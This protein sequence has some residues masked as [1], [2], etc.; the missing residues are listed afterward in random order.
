MKQYETKTSNDYMT[1]HLVC[2]HFSSS[3]VHVIDCTLGEVIRSILAR[4]D[5]PQM[6]Q[7]LTWCSNI[8]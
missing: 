1:R 7:Q 6:K 5:S 3:T 8:N 2:K 4:R